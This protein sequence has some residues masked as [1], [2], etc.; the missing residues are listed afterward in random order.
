MNKKCLNCGSEIE[1]ATL[2]CCYCGSDFKSSAIEVGNSIE[3]L[4]DRLAEADNSMT[5]KDKMLYGEMQLWRKKASIIQG[6]T[7]PATKDD[8]INL[9]IFSYSNY[10]GAK[11]GAKLLGNPVRDAWLGKAKQA[12]VMLKTMGGDDG[13]IQKIIADYASLDSTSQSK[14]S[15]SI[16][17]RIR[18]IF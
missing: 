4:Q 11:G 18:S 12:F 3:K 7:L 15:G 14:K 16:L 6:F 2:K 8:L 9:L 13:Q 10:E 17:T 5:A 1:A